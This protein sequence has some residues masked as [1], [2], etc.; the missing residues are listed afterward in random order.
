MKKIILFLP[1]FLFANSIVIYNSKSFVKT[2]KE[3][4]FKKGIGYI[5]LPSSIDKSSI[6]LSLNKEKISYYEF[7]NK[8]FY[9]LL[10]ENNLNKK[11]EFIVNNK[12]KKGVLIKIDPLIAKSNN[13]YYLLNTNKIVS[14]QNIIDSN[15]LKIKIAKTKN[16]KDRLFLSYL[17][18]NI[19]YKTNYFLNLE[20]KNILKIDSFVEI[21]NKTNQT[22][23]NFNV[24]FVSGNLE[25]N[26]YY[27]KTKNLSENI[28]ERK[29]DTVYIYSLPYKV[30]ITKNSKQFFKLFSTAVIY[31]S[32]Y[33]VY[34]MVNKKSQELNVKKIIKFNLNRLLPEG[35]IRVYKDD[36]Y[37][38]KHYINNTFAKKEIKVLLDEIFDIK[39][40][41][42]VKEY[43]DKRDY[44]RLKIKYLIENNSN[45]LKRIIIE[46]KV[47]FY[48]KFNLFKT[49]C[50]NNCKIIK[51]DAFT[52]NFITILKPKSKYKFYVIYEKR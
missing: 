22:F 43:I 9:K 50:N 7:K 5:N 13:K 38:G 12:I 6:N 28:K 25:D 14:F 46:E 34:S 27:F 44:K 52:K 18:R 32:Y 35:I 10:L 51:S 36:I 24:S 29:V 1:F 4:E 31:K 39:A 26:N 20:N 21:D 47:P 16:T 49:S 15:P 37:L 40:K 42:I 17:I 19:T 45:E 23:K 30:T 3:I 33:I 2:N 8:P 48:N 41:K 11:I